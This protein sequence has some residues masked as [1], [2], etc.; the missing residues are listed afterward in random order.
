M[1]QDGLAGSSPQNINLHGRVLNQ[2]RSSNLLVCYS[3]LSKKHPI[4]QINILL[5]P[6][7]TSK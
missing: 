1:N 3:P 4:E 6:I 5:N 2:V 7:E